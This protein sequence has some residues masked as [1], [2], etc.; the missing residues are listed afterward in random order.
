MIWMLWHPKAPALNTWLPVVLGTSRRCE[1]HHWGS[2]LCGF[3]SLTLFPVL[4]K[5]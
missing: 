2:R 4:F 1:V 5:M 3:K